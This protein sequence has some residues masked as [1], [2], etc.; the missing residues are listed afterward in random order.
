VPTIASHELRGRD[1][2]TVTYS[3]LGP[4]QRRQVF[5]LRD[6]REVPAKPNLVVERYAG[7]DE[8]RERIYD[9]LAAIESW[10]AWDPTI[11]RIEAHGSLHEGNVFAMRE[12]GF[13][14]RARVLDADRPRLL[15]W[16]G[17][18][19]GGVV[20]VHSFRMVTLDSHHTLVVERGEFKK[21][22]LRP[23]A[24]ATDFHIG[25]QFDRTLEA[26]RKTARSRWHWNHPTLNHALDIGP[27][28]P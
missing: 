19:R 3:S 8:T 22:F 25:R 4:K 6:H 21:W 24:W 27:Q 17:I 5:P 20:A 26:L 13:L 23:F 9:V 7:I 12:S 18:V 2:R 10:P 11:S 14:V 1:G 28:L 15:R 16:R